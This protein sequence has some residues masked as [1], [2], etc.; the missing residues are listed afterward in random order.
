M[1]KEII[2]STK[3]NRKFYQQYIPEDILESW[4]LE[5]NERKYA[6]EL[7]THI[8]QKGGYY[9]IDSSKS[10]ELLENWM[11]CKEKKNYLN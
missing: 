1:M 3:K 2:F 8:S 9:H 6:L 5:N 4:M 7:P 11:K 10:I